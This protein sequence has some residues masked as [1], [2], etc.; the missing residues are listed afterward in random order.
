MAKLPVSHLLIVTITTKWIRTRAFTEWIYL[1]CFQVYDM[2]PL[3]FVPT[4]TAL[5]IHSAKCILSHSRVH[6]WLRTASTSPSWSPKYLFQFSLRFW[7]SCYSSSWSVIYSSAPPTACVQILKNSFLFWA[8]YE[9]LLNH[10]QSLCWAVAKWLKSHRLICLTFLIS[11]FA[12]NKLINNLRASLMMQ[13]Q[14]AK[15]PW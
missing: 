3:R 1:V 4:R 2:D 7:C 11:I 13:P 14:S 9:I 6:W 5:P 15:K 12:G 8:F 10:S